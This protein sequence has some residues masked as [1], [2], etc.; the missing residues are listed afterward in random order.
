MQN[1][2]KES[3]V[4]KLTKV[5]S[6]LQNLYYKKKDRLKELEEEIS[7][8][9]DMLNNLNKIISQKSFTDADQ[10]YSQQAEMESQEEYED[11]DYF[12]KDMPQEKLK[13]TKIK[14]KI[15]LQKSDG[16]EEL[17]CIL[18]LYDMDKLEI[19]IL[20][21]AEYNIKETS[22]PFIK[23]FLKGALIKIKEGNPDLELSY[24][25]F[26]DTDIIE[27]I[28]ISNLKSMDSYDLITDKIRELFQ[29]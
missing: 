22:E 20:E 10:I 25:Y 24:K 17:I 2:P 18:N 23:L 8:L 7:E 14:R 3:E 28:L 5:L 13:G 1:K 19:K 29:N 15:F 6:S 4:K 26:K 27:R 11:K 9:K 16:E 21:P 12:I